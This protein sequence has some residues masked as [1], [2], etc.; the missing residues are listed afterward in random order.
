MQPK[1]KEKKSPTPRRGG[2][3][4]SQPSAAGDRSICATDT[5]I[6]PDLASV[7]SSRMD[8]GAEE[9]TF[10]APTCHNNRARR[11]SRSRRD[12]LLGDNGLKL[13]DGLLL[14][15]HRLFEVAGG[16]KLGGQ[17]LNEDGVGQGQT[18]PPNTQ[19]KTKTKRMR[20]RERD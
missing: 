10:R 11:I 14:P 4:R 13:R 1:K 16:L 18:I 17:G 15:V 12:H 8:T 2:N 5:R 3:L 7:G 20:E 6:D 9:G 19:T